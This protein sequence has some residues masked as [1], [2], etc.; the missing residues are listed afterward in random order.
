MALVPA[1]VCLGVQELLGIGADFQ[2]AGLD[3]PLEL[4]QGLFTLIGLGHGAHA[5][6]DGRPGLVGCLLPLA[7][8]DGVDT[9]QVSLDGAGL[10]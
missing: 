9:V 7:P 1:Q 8:G 4:V 2:Q 6:G 10:I 5:V 3:Q